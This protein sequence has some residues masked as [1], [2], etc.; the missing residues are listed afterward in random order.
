MGSND[1]SV[2]LGCGFLVFIILFNVFI[3]GLATEYCFE[4]W[5]SYAKGAPVDAPLYVCMIVGTIV[6]EITIPVAVITML[7][8]FAIENVYYQQVGLE[9]YK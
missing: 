9:A 3:G 7:C 4:Y 5:A 8:D 2:Y 6:A 1:K